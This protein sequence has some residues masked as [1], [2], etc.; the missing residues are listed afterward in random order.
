VTF[1][2]S[3]FGSVPPAPGARPARP[4]LLA[5]QWII[6][7]LLLFWIWWDGLRCWFIADDFAWLSLLGAVH[8]F[9]DFM[10]A[11]FVP[12]AQGT[13][14]PWSERGFFMLLESLFGLESLPYRLCV[15]ATA[16]A[17]IV[18]I[19]RLALRLSGS[20]LAAFLAPVL[21]VSN[22][23]LTAAICWTCVY[24]ELLCPL[25]LLAALLLF[26][27]WAETGRRGW[28]WWQVVVF[29]LGFGALEI[30][31]VYPALVASFCLFASRLEKRRRLLRSTLPLFLISLVYFV[32]HRAVAPIPKTGA[33]VLHF[34]QRIFPTLALYWKW[35]VLPANWPAIGI[36]RHAASAVVVVLS[37]AFLATL[38]TCLRSGHIQILF[39]PAWFLITLG[40]LLPLLEHRSDYYLTIPA[41]GIAIAAAQG[42][43]HVWRSGWTW[44]SIALAALLMYLGPMV[45]M[46]RIAAR[47][48][49][50]RDVPIRAVVLGVGQARENHPE[51]AIVLTG[52]TD[53]IYNDAVAHS[54]FLAEGVDRV[55]LTPGAEDSLHPA[56]EPEVLQ[57]FVMEPAVLRRALLDGAAV[58]YS[59]AADHLRNVTETYSRRML[60]RLPDSAPRRVEVGD[61]FYAFALGPEWGP[62]V[63]GSRQVPAK[64]TLRLGAPGNGTFLVLEGTYGPVKSGTTMTG[65]PNPEPPF[66]HLKL[67]LDGIIASEEMD[68]APV[69]R[70]RAIRDSVAPENGPNE[71]NGGFHRLFDLPLAIPRDRELEVGIDLQ[72]RSGTSSGLALGTVAIR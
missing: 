61:P 25:F 31:I 5:I 2:L 3:E 34:D 12:M 29:V 51:K 37:V 4:V 52:V 72:D 21:W 62:I 66:S 33:Y 7:I 18:L 45:R 1:P 38:V 67:T 64:A 70:Q 47:W 36:G 16:A 11:M 42:V 8:D 9:H 60:N 49:R 23:A 43:S 44:R 69:T 54:A 35:M 28:W 40:P 30:N 15:F 32:L 50:E 39:G 22:A 55:Y 41:I 24:N 68:R 48:W 13:I 58:I 59:V 57:S 27:R 10:R 6:P 56:F 46:D 14:R 53:D 26:V 63:S 20:R 65:S 17:D 19:S 71:S